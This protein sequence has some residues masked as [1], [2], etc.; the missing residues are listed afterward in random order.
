MCPETI[1]VG[2]LTLANFVRPGDGVYDDW[3]QRGWLIRNRWRML[4]SSDE[5]VRC[6]V[7]K[8]S[9]WRDALDPH[10]SV[11]SL[12]L[13]RAMLDRTRLRLHCHAVQL[14]VASAPLQR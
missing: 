13:A 12:V 14:R 8:L 2:Q 11:T 7:V 9:V 10:R 1:R 5:I 3:F 4:S 6:L